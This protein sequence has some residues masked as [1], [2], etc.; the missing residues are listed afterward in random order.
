[1]GGRPGR[2]NQSRTGFPHGRAGWRAQASLEALEETVLGQARFRGCRCR[3]PVR[4][5]HSPPAPRGAPRS[6]RRSTP[7]RRMLRFSACS[8]QR[9]SSPLASSHSCSTPAAQPPAPISSIST[10]TRAACPP[11][12]LNNRS[13]IQRSAA[14]P[15]PPASH[16]AL[17]ATRPCCCCYHVIFWECAQ[18]CCAPEKRHLVTPEKTSRYPQS[19][20][21]D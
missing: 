1:M 12:P 20:F 19:G 7:S 15:P 10:I 4:G 6:S 11:A 14:S 2:G 9:P 3:S 8:H 5:R 17:V 13:E 18:F 21:P 16:R